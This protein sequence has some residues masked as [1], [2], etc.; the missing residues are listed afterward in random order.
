M[1][2]NQ[3]CTSWP[4]FT[5]FLGLAPKEAALLVDRLLALPRT[6]RAGPGVKQTLERI[7]AA[8]DREGDRL[9]AVSLRNLLVRFLLD[10]V[11]TSGR[12]GWST[13]PEIR[14]VQEYLDEHLGEP[15]MVRDLARLV[16]LSE[17][18]LKA[19]FK[20]EVG[21]PPA[22]YRA[23]QRVERAKELLRNSDEAI[24]SIGEQLGF[25]SSQYFATVFKRY[26]GTTP[27]VYREDPD[28]V[29]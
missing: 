18:Q 15:L 26:T 13:S 25:T 12:G 27:S 23:R 20:R 28:A 3:R 10:V 17:S 4:V 16:H 5:R 9:R 2:P 24:T 11:E 21:I 1:P 6:F 29:P 8:F 7:F 19:R 22:D 14:R